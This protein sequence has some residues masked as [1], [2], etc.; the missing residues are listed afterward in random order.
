M[1]RELQSVAFAE[2]TGVTMRSILKMAVSGPGNM[3]EVANCQKGREVVA[4]C[5]SKLVEMWLVV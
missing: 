3:V 1:D 5:V 4:C 2:K